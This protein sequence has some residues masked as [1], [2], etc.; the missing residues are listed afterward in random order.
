LTMVIMT[1]SAASIGCAR[2]PGERTLASLADS[3]E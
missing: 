3:G 2:S 1:L